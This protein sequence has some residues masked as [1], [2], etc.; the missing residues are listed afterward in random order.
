MKTAL[1]IVCLL[2][3]YLI[4]P[5]QSDKDIKKNKIKSIT[6]WQSTKESGPDNPLKESFETYDKEGNM[7]Q[8][9][10][11]KADGSVDKKEV[12]RFDKSGNKIEEIKYEGDNVISSRKTL[13]YD[14][15]QNKIEEDEFSPSGILLKKTLILYQPTG[16]KLSET[17]LDGTG[18]LLKKT[19]YRYNTR[20]LKVQKITTNKSRQLES[21]KKWGYEYY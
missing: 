6:T 13:K 5:C 8:Q 11:Y 21:V 15:F 3:F 19:E 17:I 10:E 7:T 9:I 18:L 2:C 20:D 14:K 16:E 4:A 1:G 12:S